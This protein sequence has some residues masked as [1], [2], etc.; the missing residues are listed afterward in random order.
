[1]ET[2][3]KILEQI[4]QSLADEGRQVENYGILS[5]TASDRQDYTMKSGSES[6][7]VSASWLLCYNPKGV[8]VLVD[9]NPGG[10][11]FS[12]RTGAG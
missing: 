6:R 4:L 11:D 2:S 12:A 7:N 8:V 10:W 5:W 9:W 1:M 3:L